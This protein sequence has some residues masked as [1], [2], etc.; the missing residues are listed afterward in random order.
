[1][2]ESTEATMVPVVATING[3]GESFWVTPS[4]DRPN[5]GTVANALGNGAIS[6]GDVVEWND[7]GEVV[8]VV[9]RSDRATMV[10]WIEPD[11]E[12]LVTQ[13]RWTQ[14]CKEAAKAWTEQGVVVEGGFGGMLI[15]AFVRDKR[16]VLAQV[17]DLL[18]ALG[19]WEVSVELG[20]MPGYATDAESLGLGLRPRDEAWGDEPDPS[21]LPDLGDS[22]LQAA[23]ERDLIPRLKALGHINAGIDDA[24]L[25]SHAVEL[26]R[27]DYRCYE[28]C[29]SGRTD[30][31]L[32]IAARDL[33]MAK[34][35]LMPRLGGS[36]FDIDF[37]D[38]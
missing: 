36:V 12:D 32:V 22:L 15:A 26:L 20:P 11:P 29:Q 34:G 2:S 18:G 6:Y 3:Y 13:A 27:I 16:L 30:Q 23:S 5:T 9:S 8:A 17:V 33:C 19:Q 1:M 21:T 38:E 35:L 24:E 14:A 10:V 4:Q 7:N 31:V 25:L 28:S 37:L